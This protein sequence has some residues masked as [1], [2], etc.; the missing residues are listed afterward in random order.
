MRLFVGSHENTKMHLET[1]RH[2]HPTKRT[3]NYNQL[4]L[5][6][7]YIRK[8]RGAEAPRIKATEAISIT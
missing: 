8:K 7:I 4:A 1:Y 5:S 2:I 6:K 3:S